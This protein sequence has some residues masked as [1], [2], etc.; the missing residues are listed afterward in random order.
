MESNPHIFTE[1]EDDEYIWGVTSGIPTENDI[2]LSTIADFAIYKNKN[3]KYLFDLVDHSPIMSLDEKKV[4]LRKILDEFTEW[5]KKMGYT[6]AA[7]PVI[8]ALWEVESEF[9]SVE[10]LYATFKLFVTLL[11]MRG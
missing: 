1:D 7:S 11:C 8:E 2:V 9:D 4:Y 10:T 6:D 3:G 5:M